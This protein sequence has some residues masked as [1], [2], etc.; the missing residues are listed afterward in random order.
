MTPIIVFTHVGAA[1]I[2]FSSL[3]KISTHAVIRQEMVAVVTGACMTA[4]H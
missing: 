4:H 3:V 2:I 1:D